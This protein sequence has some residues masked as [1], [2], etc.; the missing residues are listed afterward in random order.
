MLNRENRLKKNKEFNYIYKKGKYINSSDFTIH[1]VDT[2]LKF[3]KFGIVV[4]KKLGNSVMRS[5]AKRV[6]SEIVRL[7][8]D[9]LAVK[10]YVLVLKPTFLEKNYNE[11]EQQFLSSMAK[12]NLLKKGL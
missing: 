9:N 1:Y 8:L 10:N 2:Y 7:N 3:S 5:R 4:N 12:F 11:L 6:M